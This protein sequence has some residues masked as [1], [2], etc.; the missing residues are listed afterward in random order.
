MSKP[1]LHLL[2]FNLIAALPLARGIACMGWTTTADARF[3]SCTLLFEDGNATRLSFAANEATLVRTATPVLDDSTQPY[4]TGFVI[5]IAA[6]H[7]KNA[8]PLFTLND[9][10]GNVERPHKI[11]T[12]Q[13]LA[14]ER[15]LVAY[16]TVLQALALTQRDTKLHKQ[17]QKQNH[18][19]IEARSLSLGRI[20]QCWSVAGHL[21]LIGQIACEPAQLLGSTLL[22]GNKPPLDVSKDLQAFALPAGWDNKGNPLQSQATAFALLCKQPKT[23]A[24]NKLLLHINTRGFG[25]FNFATRAL[26]CE[27]E[28]LSSILAQHRVLTMCVL[29]SLQHSIKAAGKQEQLQALARDVFLQLWQQAQANSRYSN[30]YAAGI[31]AAFALE[32]DGL[33]L[34]GNLVAPQGLPAQVWLYSN[35]QKPLNVSNKLLMLPAGEDLSKLR[36]AFPGAADKTF[37]VLHI[38]TR[39]TGGERRALRISLPGVP[40]LWLK[41]ETPQVQAQGLPLARNMLDALPRSDY[42]WRNFKAVF[43]KDLG[44]A[45]DRA[46]SQLQQKRAEPTVEQFGTPPLKPR[47]SVI[48]PL[49][50]RYDFMRFQLAHFCDD[51]DFKTVDL[52][53]VVDDPSLHT[54]AL[55]MAGNYQPLFK[56]PFRVVTYPENRGFAGANNTAVALARAPLLVLLNSD[57]LPQ[58]T[59]WLSILQKAFKRLPDCGMVGPL[60]QFPEGSVQHAGMQA[61]RQWA[62]PDMIFSHHPGKGTAWEGGNKATEQDMLTGACLMLNKS[63]YEAAGGL[64]EGYIVGDFEDSDLSL[65]M[66]ALGKRLY[67]VP[68]AKLW[69]LER[70]SQYLGDNKINVRDMLTM[71]N[72]WRYRN[73]IEAGLLPNPESI[74]VGG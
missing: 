54:F 14:H 60:L 28:A 38:N 39:S 42:L 72:A 70:Q 13:L 3:D 18:A 19:L 50:G 49:Y 52:I 22:I 5:W 41:V 37:F 57:I 29:E 17:L 51:P 59:G 55:N 43:D 15:L 68:A 40:E 9:Q 44:K 73:K 62:N 6:K 63:D 53:Y 33:L 48:V 47:I 16:G 67:L 2:D 26:P 1:V 36:A 64:D 34:M 4:G 7:F 56:I 25:N 65:C 10:L 66:R 74:Q 31:S 58:H 8:Q 23:T 32:K 20:D 27:L 21:L 24:N 69:H 46:A 11:T 35:N 71:Y 45:L 12:A 61:V 30:I